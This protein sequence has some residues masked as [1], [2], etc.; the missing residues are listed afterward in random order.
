MQRP[1]SQSL[2]FACDPTLRTHPESLVS[3]HF[4]LY[5]I[6]C[7]KFIRLGNLI[8]TYYP[9]HGKSM[10]KIWSRCYTSGH[11]HPD[12]TNDS[13]TDPSRTCCS[14]TT[15]SLFPWTLGKKKHPLP[16][17]QGHLIVITGVEDLLS[18]IQIPPSDPQGNQKDSRLAIASSQ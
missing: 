11:D 13:S 18:V 1:P 15:L 10:L 16:Y 8:L 17:T 14:T 9:L 4:Q 7:V 5:Y 6:F 3:P 12:R 2:V